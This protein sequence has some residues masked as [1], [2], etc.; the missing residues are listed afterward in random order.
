MTVR[1][2]MTDIVLNRVRV[3][4][5]QNHQTNYENNGSRDLKCLPQINKSLGQIM[6][7]KKYTLLEL[8]IEV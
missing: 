3:H 5:S 4:E 2:G 7:K 1:D 8:S 6:L